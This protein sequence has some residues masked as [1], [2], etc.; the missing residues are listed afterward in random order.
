MARKTARHNST[1]S[2]PQY[3]V[4][5][6]ASAGGMQAIHDLF[7]HLPPATGFAFVVVQHLSPDYKSLMVELLAKHTHMPVLEAEHGMAVEANCV[8]AI[9][10]KKI[11][12]IQGGK[13]QLVEKVRG[14]HPNMAIDTFFASLAEDKGPD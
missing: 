4:G 14:P 9:P 10:N 1:V 11:M 13:L 12:T 7:D 2:P 5:I 3:V 8:Y 6:G